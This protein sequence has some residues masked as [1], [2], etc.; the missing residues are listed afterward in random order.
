M[1]LP[2]DQRGGSASQYLEAGLQG[3]LCFAPMCLLRNTWYSPRV[4]AM[5]CSYVPSAVPPSICSYAPATECP[6]LSW[7][8]MLLQDCS[9]SLPPPR[10]G[11]IQMLS[12]LILSLLQ[13]HLRTHY[14]ILTWPYPQRPTT[15]CPVLAKRFHLRTRTTR[16]TELTWRIREWGPSPT[17]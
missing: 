6:V 11:S 4:C 8:S 13:V 1:L 12:A 3:G 17:R 14:A 5:L 2:G 16:N 10:L 9:F 15:R 7:G